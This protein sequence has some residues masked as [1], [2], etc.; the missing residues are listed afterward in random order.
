MQPEV[1][2]IVNEDRNRSRQIAIRS[3]RFTI[4]RSADN[5]LSVDDPGLSR[6]HAL[7]EIFDGVAEISDC[8][9]QNGT[10]VNDRPIA[11]SARLND[12]DLISLGSVCNITVQVKNV[13][14]VLEPSKG[15]NGSG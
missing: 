3:N 1:V 14:P 4:G 15:A 7:I 13:R 12:G 2:L 11:E 10:F 6:R 8:G 9:S 5:D